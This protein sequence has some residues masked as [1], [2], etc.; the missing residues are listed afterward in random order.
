MEWKVKKEGSSA[1]MR[2]QF[3]GDRGSVPAPL[4]GAAVQQKVRDALIGYAAKREQYPELDADAYMR[5]LPVSAVSTYGGNTSCVEVCCDDTRLVLDMG[6]GIRP[7]GNSLFG[8]MLKNRGLDITFLVSHVHWDHIQ[9]LPF[10]GPL[11]INKET[12]I[13]NTWNFYGGTNWMQTVEVCL[14][15]QMDPPNFPVSWDEIAA[16]T[17]KIDP[18][19]L[20]DM[21]Q[22]E[23][24]PVK[25]KTRKLNHPQETYGF[26]I[27]YDGKVFAYTTDNEPFDP[28]NPDPRLLELCRGAD[29]WV[30]DSQYLK[31]IYEGKEGGVP[32]HGWGHSYPE[33]VAATAVLGDVHRT[34]LFHYDPA[35][36][37]E[38]IEQMQSIC[39]GLLESG[40]TAIAAKEGLVIEV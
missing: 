40:Q 2:V 27:E 13:K 38:R 8:E 28:S 39:Q 6:T 1:M 33:A 22:F 9:G 30:T 25:V 37:D 14:H 29:V 32:R 21:K 16:I 24:G 23:V 4:T 35:S 3:W 18:H 26:R 12:G 20:Y 36:S 10:F 19:S 7:L 15:G 31:S 34:V 11:Y 5:S 17:H